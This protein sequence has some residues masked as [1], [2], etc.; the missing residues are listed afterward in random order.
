MQINIIPL[1]RVLLSSR[2]KDDTLFHGNR[3]GVRKSQAD[4]RVEEKGY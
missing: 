3:E 2:A 1:M 4:Y